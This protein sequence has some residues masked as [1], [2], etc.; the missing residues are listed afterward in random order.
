MT[1]VVA[2]RRSAHQSGVVASSEANCSPCSRNA[3]RSAS[4]PGL[5][6]RRTNK[7]TVIIGRVSDR[8]MC[9]W[10]NR[11]ST[12]VQLPR[13]QPVRGSHREVFSIMALMQLARKITDDSVDHTT[14]LHGRS[15]KQR[16]GPPPHVLVLV[17][18]QELSSVVGPAF[19]QPSIPRK[20]GDVRNRIG[21]A[22]DELR[23]GKPAVEHVELPLHLHREPIDCVL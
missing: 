21:A 22:G 4:L 7:P 15:L 14:T 16:I 5:A 8:Y 18:T 20:D 17:H 9:H 2:P 6:S 13:Y 10:G 1:N 11:Q 23:L 3:T 12:E 19:D